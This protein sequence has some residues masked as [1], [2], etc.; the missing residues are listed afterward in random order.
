MLKKLFIVSIFALIVLGVLAGGAA[1]FTFHQAGSSPFGSLQNA[2]SEIP[3]APEKAIVRPPAET[4]RG[5]SAVQKENSAL[6]SSS[7]PALKINISLSAGN[8]SY[9]IAVPRGATAYDA[10]TAVA[11]ENSNFTF[12]SKL[13]SGLGYF[14][15][16]INSVPNAGGKYWT[17]YINGKYSNVG[18]SQYVL[19]S[20]DKV[21]WRFENNNQ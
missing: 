5:E 6:E 3:A 12:K 18:A 15:Q 14:I 8:S 1:R 4:I 21:E 9:S 19:M 11:A 2:A 13:Y 7:A 16:E 20:G 10:M 17:L